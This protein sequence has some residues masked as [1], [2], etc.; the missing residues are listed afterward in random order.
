[1]QPELVTRNAVIAVRVSSDRQFQE[2]DS[3]EAQREQL[4]VYA[5]SLGAKV[6]KVFVFAESGAKVNQPMQEA[7]DYCAD[8]RN[9]IQLFLIKSIDR[10]TRGGA[11]FYGPLKHQLDAIGVNLV[12]KYGIISQQR[13]NTLEHLGVEYS[14]SNYSPSQKTEYLE[15]E[16]AKDELRDILSRMIG[17]EVRYTRLGYWMRQAP[18]GFTTEKIETRN[19]KRVILKPHPVEAPLIRRLFELRAAGIE[20]DKEIIGE[21]NVMG[22]KT[23]LHYVRSKHNR[24]KI[25][26]KRGGN[27]LDKDAMD[28]FLRNP[29]YAGINNEKWTEGKPVRT[30]FDGLV[31]IEM[32][33]A[34][35]RG[36][37]FIAIEGDD[38]TI[39]RK[40][41]PEH[42]LNKGIKNPNFPYR[43]FIGCSKCGKP[44]YGSSS[45]GYNGTHYPAYHCNKGHYFRVPKD[46]LEATVVEFIRCISLKPE[47][48]DLIT[49]AVMSEWQ[50]REQRVEADVIQFDQQ[51]KELETEAE[52]TVRKLKMVE[53]E[54][55]IKYMEADL[56]SIE[57][58]IRDINVAK[59]KKATT[60]TVDMGKIVGRVK[61][62]LENLDKLLLQ[63]IDPVKKAQF[64]GV[65]FDRIPTYEEIKTGTK[66]LVKITEVSKLFGLAD[67]S[68]PILVAPPRLELGTQGSSSLCSTN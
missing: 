46:E 44:M 63:Q 47:Q 48:I 23:R 26:G 6:Q 5:K 20:H 66:N 12:D 62:F 58:K 57:Q 28:L 37:V 21:L 31:D 2:G 8:K 10:F 18:Y 1:M 17:A 56:M 16:R 51:I 36:K 45:R 53:S 39:E 43:R 52:A 38:I 4:E 61:Y 64:F 13:V 40:F 22:F 30:V 27:P 29:I 54:T 24:T 67:L 50:R 3:P 35:N 25:I 14:W 15:A 11:D 55:A 68:L 19:G 34:A 42:Q 49:T 32:F 60:N 33:N 65:F 7:I 41:S 9:N 59:E